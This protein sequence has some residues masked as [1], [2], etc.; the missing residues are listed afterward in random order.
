MAN[1]FKEYHAER[2]AKELAKS[3]IRREY[4]RGDTI[5]INPIYDENRNG[6]RNLSNELE[7]VIVDEK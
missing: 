7:R 6:K 1:F 3:T 2:K 4:N 5:H